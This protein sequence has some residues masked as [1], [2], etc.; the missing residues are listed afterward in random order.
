MFCRINM[1]PILFSKKFQKKEQQELTKSTAVNSPITADKYF[2][3]PGL[4]MQL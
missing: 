3:K 2:D 4:N 1:N